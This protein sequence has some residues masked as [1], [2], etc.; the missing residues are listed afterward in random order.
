MKWRSLDGKYRDRI[1]AL[2]EMPAHELLGV[3]ADATA[4]EVKRAYRQKAKAYHP[5]RI[6]PFL[7]P[8]GEEIMKLLNRAYQL[9]LGGVER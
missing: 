8:H 5:D 4:Q 3:A 6:D 1:A 7:R 2:R 9:M